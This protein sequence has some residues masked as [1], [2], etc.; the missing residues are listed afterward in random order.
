MTDNHRS[1]FLDVSGLLEPRSI[2]VIGASDRAG[3]LGGDTVQ[4]LIKFKFPGPVWPVNP[5]ASGVAGLTCYPSIRDLPGI[6]DLVIMAIP[7]DGLME[8]IRE[9]IAKGT[10]CGIAYSGGLAEAGGEG[11]VLQQALIDLCQSADFKLCGPNCVGILNCATPVTAT[12][13]TALYDLDSLTPGSISMVSQSGGLGTGFFKMVHGAGF[14]FRHLISSGNE[15]VVGFA[16]YLYALAQD[17]GTAVIAAYL[18][19]VLDG[20][21]LVRALAEAKRQDKPVVIVKSGAGQ[22]SAR[23]AQAHTGALVGEDRVFDA[24]LKEMGAIRVYSIEE[25][26]DV[27]LLIAGMPKDRRPKGPGVG[28]VTFG[29]GNGVL[30]VDQSEQAGLTVPALRPEAVAELKTLL[31]S[32]ATASNPMDLTPG[33]AF[34]AESLARLPAALDVML[35]EPQIDTLL[36]IASSLASKAPEISKIM[37]EVSERSPKPVCIAWPDT[38]PGVA[39]YLGAAGM[40]VFVEPARAARAL[41]RLAQNRLA[42]QGTRETATSTGPAFDWAAHVPAISTFPHVISEH[43]CHALMRAAGLP[44]AEGQLVPDAEAARR[45]VAAIGL[46]VAIKGISPKVTHRAAAGLVAIDLR[47]EA[48][49]R[50]ACNRM[51]ERA[52]A[53]NVTLDGLYVQKMVRGGVE[54]LVSAFRDPIFGPVISCGVGGG[55]TELVDDIVIERAPVG[56]VTAA[57]MV[58]RLRIRR[59]ARDEAGPLPAD[60]AARFIAR[61]S[62]LAASAPWKAFMLEVN[63]IKWTR[64]SAIAVDGL[65]IIDEA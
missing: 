64:N 16:D 22:A 27:C 32:T 40:P 12:F 17:P 10:R 37:R 36:M 24:I 65:L 13:A 46:P 1:P 21:K 8:A 15:A 11:A 51:L 33:T 9:S 50:E 55:L 60:A 18:E 30:G 19:G 42:P 47:S 54:L 35:A 49:V 44:V 41:G 23:A 26:A 43:E 31:V 7:A 59:H 38:P 53:I 6:P 58:E 39:D 2:A 4:R 5:T 57:S 61:L 3:N 34:R 20:P 62:E 52:K 28:I 14:G 48:E 56:L 29:G 25:L 63:P 45:A